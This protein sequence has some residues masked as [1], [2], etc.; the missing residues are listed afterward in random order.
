MRYTVQYIP[1]SKIRPGFS[2][3]ITRR[4]KELRK[5]AQD[6]MHLMVV[7]KSRKEGGY[8]IISGTSHFDYLQKHTKQTAAPCLIDESQASSKW[9][10]LV[11]RMRKRK[12]PYEVP[13]I[14][15]ERTPVKSYAII[16]RFLKQEPRF[17]ALSRRQQIKVLRLGLQY[18]KTTVL[19][20]KAMVDDILKTRKTV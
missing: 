9:N 14:G 7:R 5:A 3:R 13:Y 18:K 16:R 10:S 17:K 4:I 20:M 11:H 19:S 1:L 2:D 15:R 8:V 6:C 12:L